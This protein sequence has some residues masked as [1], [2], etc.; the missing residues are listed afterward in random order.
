[1]QQCA[2][3]ALLSYILVISTTLEWPHFSVNLTIW[4]LGWMNFGFAPT[5]SCPRK[6]YDFCRKN[7]VHVR[8][9]RICAKREA[10]RRQVVKALMTHKIMKCYPIYYLRLTRIIRRYFVA[11]IPSQLC[12]V[13][14]KTWVQNFSIVKFSSFATGLTE[15]LSWQLLLIWE[16]LL[17]PTHGV[18]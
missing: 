8:I 5:F 9:I 10:E 7:I 14:N 16:F 6:L 18:W 13:L 3:M 1:M 15:R 17:S 4:L 2:N 11:S 12:L